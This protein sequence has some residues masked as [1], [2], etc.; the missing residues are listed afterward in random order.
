MGSDRSG[1]MYYSTLAFNMFNGKL[2]VAVAKSTNGGKTW[3]TPVPVFRPPV[4]TFYSGDKDALA[5]GPD[6][7]VTNRDTI[8]VAYDDTSFDIN[9]NQA[10]TGLPVAR[11][12]NGGKTWQLHYADKFIQCDA[13]DSERASITGTRTIHADH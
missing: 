8:Y 7:A 10:F 2:D 3:S 4:T 12:I 13:C 11:S 1:A 6:P 5:V 9:T